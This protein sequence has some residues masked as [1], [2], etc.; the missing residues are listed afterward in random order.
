L[1]GGRPDA[2][3][4]A[5]FGV[6]DLIRVAGER[7]GLIITVATAVVALTFIV[8]LF[9]PNLY[10]STAVVMLDTRRNAVADFS[11]VLTALPT[12][13][14]SLQNQ[15]QLLTSRDLAANVIARTHLYDDPDFAGGG[16]LLT[17]VRAAFTS[18]APRGSA[19]EA[20][21]ALDSIIEKFLSRLD[22]ETQGLSTAISVKFTARDPETAARVANA[23]VQ[24]YIEDQLTTKFEANRKTTEWLTT[25]V[26]Q[27]GEQVQAAEAA[28]QQYR[29]EHSLDQIADGTPLVDQQMAGI[30]AQVVLAR[31]D[32]AQKTANYGRVVALVG[33]G[34]AGDVSQIVASPLI[35]QLRGQEAELLKQESEYA[36][37]YGPKHP[38]MIAAEQQKRDLEAKID[39]EVTRISGAMANDV[40][41]ARA[42]LGS[43]E[44]SLKISEREAGVQNFARV[45]LK[46]LEGNAASTRA[47]YDSFVT[48][49][50]QTQNQDEIQNSDA[51]VISRA[52]VPNAPSSP[53]RTLI[54]AASIPAG[55][56]LGLLAA[57]LLE[58]FGASLP[59][60][61]RRMRPRPIGP[62]GG[63]PVVA[64]VPN[65]QDARA[66]DY[67]IDYP[68][69]AFA[70]AMDELAQRLLAQNTKVLA[71]TS[72][73]HGEGKT[74]IAV[75]LA[76]AAA[77]RGA[78]VVVVEGDL[79]RPMASRAFGI[80]A[81][82]AGVYEATSR[83]LPLS[84]CLY[85]DPRSSALVLSSPKPLRDP[86]VLLGSRGFAQLIAHLRSSSDLVIVD[87]APA[88]SSNDSPQSARLAD[89]IL[90]VVRNSDRPAVS[91]AV[92]AMQSVGVPP[93]GVV[94]AV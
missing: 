71:V 93:I 15:I 83:S 75:A 80:A 48:R 18:S 26:R 27:L 51:R 36:S 29:A 72:A 3:P 23:V 90:M 53:K 82:E 63:A 79:K 78:R 37:K 30:S 7:A 65:A 5:G 52:A 87:S 88:L 20:S 25:R 89:A 58:R 24:A 94:L 13:A 73:Q 11:S 46:E 66:P 42:Q 50:R 45:K 1:P 4:D 22:V 64:L 55:L 77:R 68:T 54:L 57:L 43:L 40:A 35:V 44:G 86:H 21:A 74:T 61:A 91:G 76:R 81:V 12:D 92:D 56:L 34:H 67:V 85:K 33:S 62:F 17:S 32:L 9:L 19:E 69:S 41:A 47:I 84:R 38:K 59:R 8:L 14:A 49:L 2:V 28:A 60:T 16:G 31:A 39:Q 70:Q 10:S 6:A